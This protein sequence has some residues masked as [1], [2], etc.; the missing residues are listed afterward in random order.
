MSGLEE[1]LNDEVSASEPV[2]QVEIVE[3]Q[4]EAVEPE[5]RP[6]DEH[7]RFAPKGETEGESPAPVEEKPQLE[8]PAL[9]GERRRRQE[10]E[11]R[12]ADLEARLNAQPVAPPPS[13]F[14][15]EDAAWAARSE[16]FLSV[17]EQ[18]A[19]AK[20]EERLIARS[21]NAA[22]G[23]YQDFDDVVGTFSELAQSNPNLERQL[24]DAENPG[25]FAY[26]TA[27]AHIEL[28]QHGGDIN[29]LVAARVK[30]ELEKAPQP[31]PK[32]EVAIPES[33]AGAQSARA[34]SATAPKM[35]TLD[36]ILG[37]K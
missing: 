10:A 13:V 15:D 25:E 14:D 21:A 26:T 11:A 27:K 22:R 33:L 37:R 2:E 31:E 35:P 7:G 24:R 5:Q 30:A 28:Q 34:S 9:I 8:H 12:A 29:A 6:R 16:Q 36:E 4:P 20:F 3:E 17:A 1:I 18:R 19:M 32:P 23:K